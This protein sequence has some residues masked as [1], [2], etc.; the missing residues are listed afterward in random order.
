MIAQRSIRNAARVI[1]NRAAKK[2]LAMEERGDLLE[3][4]MTV[5]SGQM[6]KEAYH[7]RN[8][9]GAIIACGQ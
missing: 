8:L 1:R 7:E 6:G 9:A 5:I 2:T 4:L 3:D